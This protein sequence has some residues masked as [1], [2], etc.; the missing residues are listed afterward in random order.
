[1]VDE[2]LDRLEEVLQKIPFNLN[3]DQLG[4]IL[5]YIRGKG[6]FSLLGTAGVG[7]S[8]I[9]QVLKLY[10]E[11]EMVLSAASGVANQGL[12]DGKGGDGTTHKVMSLPFYLGDQ[13]AIQKVNRTCS[14]IFAGSDLVKHICID[15]AY[16]HNPEHLMVILK[17]L[18]RF[19]KKTAKRG[20]RNIRLLFVGDPCQLGSILSD[21]DKEYLLETYGSHLMFESNVWRD[22]SPTIRVLS[23]VER[24][25]D[26]TF[27]AFL[28]V[29]RYGQEDRYE[30]AL[31]WINKRVNYNYDN[32]KFTVAT[33][34]KTVN[35]VNTKV[36]N[37]MTTQKYVSKAVVTGDFNFKENGVEE[38]ITLCEGLE[39]ITTVNDKNGDFSNGSFCTI[40]MVTPHEGCYCLFHHSGKEVFVPIH[41]YEQ[42]E[43][44]VEGNVVNEDGTKGKDILK[45]KVVGTCHQHCLLQASSFS[46]YRSQGRTFNKEGVLDIGWGFDK[47]K[48]FGKNA[49]YVMASRWVSVDQITLP[50]PLE[51]K[52][53]HVCRPSIDF[54]QQ[55]VK[56]QEDYELTEELGRL[57]KVKDA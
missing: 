28:E 25:K 32:S 19:N 26:K 49:L 23:K 27:T 3:K 57:L 54:W 35:A 21:K 43:S 46:G 11:D 45:R 8:V 17:R 39:C 10:Y 4:F 42:V 29:L 38:E 20:R 13:K 56:E 2:V 31:K 40:T 24:Q 36:L 9:I 22:F 52:H 16:M 37:S 30:G 41:E 50:R 51:V 44:Y 33:Y 14:A 5:E 53:I 18:E 7:K 12:C 48:D 15:E 47:S 6:H 55:C 1:M 34:L